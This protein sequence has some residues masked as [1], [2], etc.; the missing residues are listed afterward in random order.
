MDDLLRIHAH[1]AVVS[2]GMIPVLP[3]NS[4]LLCHT[5]SVAELDAIET[6]VTTASQKLLRST[7]HIVSFALPAN[8]YDKP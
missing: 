3:P 6:Y 5:I 7:N 1:S 4:V 2:N 8:R